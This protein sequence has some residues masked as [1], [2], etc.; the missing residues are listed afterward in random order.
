MIAK[1]CD[2]CG[3]LYESATKDIDGEEIEGIKTIG[4]VKYGFSSEKNYDLC[5]D[6][7]SS[8]KSWIRINLNNEEEKD[9]Y[10]IP[11]YMGE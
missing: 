10:E 6:C 7:L 8:F 2:R 11:T 3:K 4:K 1:K 5:E 9:P